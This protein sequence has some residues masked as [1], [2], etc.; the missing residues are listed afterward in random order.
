MCFLTVAAVTS[1]SVAAPRAATAQAPARL[2]S[3]ALVQ[4]LSNATDAARIPLLLDLA[5][6]T[7][8]D[9][10]VTLRHA[11]EALTLITRHPSLRDEIRARLA[12]AF[13][14]QLL[15]EYP[16]ALTAAEQAARQSTAWASEDADI[17]TA[18]RALAADALYHV[19]LV[20]WRMA[21]YERGLTNAQ[22]ARALLTSL[23]DTPAQAKTLSLIGA[24]H[25][26]QSQLN[27]SLEWYLASLRMSE[28][29]G[30]EIAMGRAHNNI[31]LVLIELD[32]NDEAYAA[33]M[34]ALEIHERRG[35]R[36][37]LVNTLNNV[38]MVLVR[39]GRPR[40]AIPHLERAL[41]IDRATGNRFGEAKEYSNIGGAHERLKDDK[42]ALGFHERALAIREAIGDKD[43]IVISQGAIAEVRMRLGDARGAVP[44]FER[45]VALAAEINSRRDEAD[46]L[47]L[48]SQ[49]REIVGDTAGAFRD[50]RRYHTLNA[51]LNDST[52]QR[53]FAELEA[54]YQ[55]V[56]R[57]RELAEVSA[58][59]ES[60][61]RKV[62]ALIFG[63]ALLGLCLALLAV[64]HVMRG[65][66][67]QALAESEERYR[68][69]FHAS[70]VPTF[71][72]E[73]ATRRL[74]DCNAPARGIVTSGACKEVAVQ[75]LEPEWVRRALLRSLEATGDDAVAVE[76]A[77]TGEGGESRWTEIR[78]SKVSSAGRGCLLVTVRDATEEHRRDVLRQREE[79]L[80]SLGVL[81]GG[82][83]HDFNNAL[84]AVMGHIALARGADDSEREEMLGGAETAARGAAR[85]TAQLLAFSKGGK[86]V[87]RSEDIARLLRDTVALVGAGSRMRVEFDIP[88][89]LWPARV[90]SGQFSQLV[91]NIVINAQQATGEGG[92]LLVRAS[93]VCGDVAS[94]HAA[95]TGKVGDG[96]EREPRFVRLD[97]EDNGG[98]ISEAIRSRV[99]D[100]YFTTKSG[101]S[102][103]GLA[104]AFAI[105]RHHG[106]TLTFESREGVGTTFSVY[107]PATSEP[108]ATAA[109]QQAAMPDGNASI[110]LLD[111][112]PLVR[113]ILTRLLEK[114]GFEVE[115]VGE[116]REAV[117]R[118]VTRMREGRRFD[119]LIMDL[120]IPGGMGGRQALAEILRHDPD[121]RAIVASG[122]SDDPT[123]AHFAEAGFRAA[124]AKPFQLDELAH[125]VNAVLVRSE[126]RAYGG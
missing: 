42:T 36:Q 44:L 96:T 71:L 99:F 86:P 119:L 47:R 70:S 116:G 121:A 93:N 49:A 109:P 34:R 48:L 122:Y 40:E 43:G 124:L 68:A 110:L 103:L 79:K 90:D 107:L 50:F 11:D 82:I 63:S 112:E 97:F 88:A 84:T 1:W 59:S 29:M 113:N 3:A 101:G 12:R 78:G 83:A 41:A 74:I 115:G 19:G 117:D 28:A 27:E 92:K 39:V 105:C 15:G 10:A 80:Q 24:I 37:F 120:T 17:P 98:G 5:Q 16:A 53:Q 38:G 18:D 61:R 123:M 58:L 8:D 21:Q 69:L 126:V 111:D 55:S 30:D 57:Q 114:W 6:L 35:T 72:L 32:R 56:A 54:R 51:A 67:Q 87:R 4:A 2:D 106:G 94:S 23:G 89:S 20:Q 91:S 76:D 31:G 65:R 108:P 46:L 45:A 85:L 9:P 77:W 33:L 62:Q 7:S 75:D 52:L 73:Q 95:A 60:R 26:V 104:T 22:R 125:V 66:A 118:Y 13:S 100:P 14:L 102:G 81:A 25:F 64:M